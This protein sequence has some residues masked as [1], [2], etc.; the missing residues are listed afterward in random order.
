MIEECVVLKYKIYCKRI[1]NN[2]YIK[3]G[4]TDDNIEIQDCK[5]TLFHSNMQLKH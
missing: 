3:I 5:S 4:N 1:Y 2:I